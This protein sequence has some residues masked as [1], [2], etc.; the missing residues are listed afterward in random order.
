MLGADVSIKRLALNLNQIQQ[1]NPPPNPAKETDTRF[2]GY[3][4]RYGDKSWELDALEPQ[5]LD[6]LIT[7]NIMSCL[8]LELFD[9]M[10]QLQEVQ[11]QEII[12]LAANF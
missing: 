5:I 12:K 3:K 10:K 8:D 9:A 6:V 1:Y 7:E 2:A 4:D 11:R